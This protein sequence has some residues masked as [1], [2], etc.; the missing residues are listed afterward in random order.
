M[1]K[2]R[3]LAYVSSLVFNTP[4]LLAP[5]KLEAISQ[6]L[7]DARTDK[8]ALPDD[9]A[10]EQK[11]FDM[12]GSVG[13]I[14][15]FGTLVHRHSWLSSASGMTS[16]GDLSKTLY[17]AVMDDEISQIVFLIDSPGGEAKGCFDLVGEIRAARKE[18]PIYAYA[19]G[20][21]ASAAYA[22]GSA[23]ETVVASKFASIGSIGVIASHVDQSAAL[24]QEGYRIT[25]IVSGENK[26][27]GNPDEPL[28][29]ANRKKLQARVDAVADLF[30]AEVEANRPNLSKDFISALEAGIFLG[31]DAQKQG[32]VDSVQSWQDFIQARTGMPIA[33]NEERDDAM[34]DAQM[35]ALAQKLGLPETASYEEILAAAHTPAPPAPLPDSGQ[36]AVQVN[37]PAPLPNPSQ[38]ALLAELGLPADADEATVK[39]TVREMRDRGQAENH[40]LKCEALV[41]KAIA[42]RKIYAAEAPVLLAEA[43]QEYDVTEKRIAMRPVGAAG[44]PAPSSLPPAAPSSSHTPG[45]DADRAKILAQCGVTEERVQKYRHKTRFGLP[46]GK[47]SDEKK[48]VVQPV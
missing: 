24:Q 20:M 25:H 33:E 8:L 31:E 16:Y 14:P 48:A 37:A 46:A 40:R 30:F 32:L 15:V 7:V 39:A 11:D 9:M 47:S 44:V 23:A 17:A 45:E 36:T 26:A 10:A 6:V 22:I 3:E 19:E 38:A 12:A 4:L 5:E 28:S 34:N 41:Q 27:L 35:K 21:M 1:K 13:I 2:N 43:I 42:D 18:K 29:D